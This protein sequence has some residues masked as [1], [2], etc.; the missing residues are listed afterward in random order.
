MRSST[1]NGLSLGVLSKMPFKN[2]KRLEVPDV[3]LVE[4]VRFS[5]ERGFFAELYKRTDFLANG[6]PY[7]FV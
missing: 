4:F 5:D 7:D 1:G 3:I 6:I 2:F